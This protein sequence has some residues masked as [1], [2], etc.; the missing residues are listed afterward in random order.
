MGHVVEGYEEDLR[1][2]YACSVTSDSNVVTRE[3]DSGRPK[4]RICNP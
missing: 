2:R 3:T 4:F 1:H